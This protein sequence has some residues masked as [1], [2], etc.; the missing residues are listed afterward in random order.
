MR[1]KMSTHP[2]VSAWVPNAEL[3]LDTWTALSDADFEAAMRSTLS[4]DW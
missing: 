2:S 3:I 4:L 1:S